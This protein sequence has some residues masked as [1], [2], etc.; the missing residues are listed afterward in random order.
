M[1]RSKIGLRHQ[2]IYLIIHLHFNIFRK[3]PSSFVNLSRHDH[4]LLREK[5][6]PG[7]IWTALLH[8]EGEK[9]ESLQ[10]NYNILFFILT[11]C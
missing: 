11:T 3:L 8:I 7:Y 6:D 2:W 1:K 10:C 9:R 5:S 4:P